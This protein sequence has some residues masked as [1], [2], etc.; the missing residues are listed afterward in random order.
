MQEHVLSLNDLST[1]KVFDKSNAEYVL[2]ARLILLE[3]GKYQSHPEMGVGIKSRYRFNNSENV[4]DSL[5]ADIKEQISKYL[6]TLIASEVS[7]TLK[8]D[9]ILGIIINTDSGMYTFA[10]DTENESLESGVSYI[11]NDLI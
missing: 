5:A 7:L 6:P 8:K 11:L 1:P 2:I 3:P 4:L 9:H 10:Y